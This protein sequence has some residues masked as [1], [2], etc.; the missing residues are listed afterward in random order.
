MGRSWLLSSLLHTALAVVLWF[1]LPSWGRPLPAMDSA[2]TVELVSEAPEDPRPPEPEIAARAPEPE[3][4]A[5][6]PQPMPPRPRPQPEPV[7][8]PQPEPRPA[9][10]P[11]PEPEPEIVEP[12]PTPLPEPE[13]AEPEPAP[14]PEAEPEIAAQPEPEQQAAL[15][16]DPSPPPAR[17][18]PPRSTPRPQTKP[19]TPPA[20]PPVETKPEP[21]PQEVARAEPPPPQ[22]EPPRPEPPAQEDE[23]LAMLRSVEEM[24]RQVQGEVQQQGTGRNPD[25]AGRARTEVGDGQITQSEKDALYRQITRNWILPGGAEHVE[26]VVV[27][28]RI[29]V[30]PDRSVR[31]VIIQD[32]ARLERDPTFRVV[33]ES[34]YRA[35]ERSSPLQ[36]PPDKY[37]LWRDLVL[38]FSPRDAIGG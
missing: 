29:Q 16:P 1:G 21:P 34:A 8:Q 4:E 33:A 2:I 22:P 14:A 28:L 12:E 35:V 27:Q 15:E 30:A 10:E 19:T 31:R 24:P 13:V 36:L 7:V 37:T 3:R 38:N 5:A 6:R 26:D 20:P 11:A 25:T 23:F 18:E 17:P 9:P 32:Q